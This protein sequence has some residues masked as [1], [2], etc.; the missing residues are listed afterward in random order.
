M[1]PWKRRRR[2]GA[3]GGAA[4]WPHT[5]TH[6]RIPDCTTDTTHE[7]RDTPN[8]VPKN[9]A[10][11][12]SAYPYDG[13]NRLPNNPIKYQNGNSVC[14]IGHTIG[15]LIQEKVL[16][17]RSR[18]THDMFFHTATSGVFFTR[19]NACWSQAKGSAVGCPHFFSLGPLHQRNPLLLTLALRGIAAAYLDMNVSS[20]FFS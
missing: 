11:V 5:H 19:F 14:L 2:S 12:M 16:R 20:A 3:V 15:T 4:S 10:G 1:C 17:Q 18:H 7:T 9:S 13:R 6:T 8:R